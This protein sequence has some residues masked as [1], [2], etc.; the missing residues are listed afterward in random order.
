MY[1]IPKDKDYPDDSVQ[2][3]ECGGWGCE[4]CEERG[5]FTPSN[6]SKGRKCRNDECNKPLAPNHL[7]VYCSISCALADA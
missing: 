7:A 3:D 4:E 2:C 5:W 1:N 6:H